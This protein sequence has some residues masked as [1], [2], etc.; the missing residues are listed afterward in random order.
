MSVKCDVCGKEVKPQVARQVVGEKGGRGQVNKDCIKKPGVK[1]LI[2]KAV[3]LLPHHIFNLWVYGMPTPR[4]YFF[5][6]LSENLGVFRYHFY[7][8]FFS[9]CDIRN[10]KYT[11]L[12]WTS[13]GATCIATTPWI[14][15]LALSASILICQSHIS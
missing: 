11:Y 9:S 12:I 7:S 10:K 4:Q 13:G 14:T 2:R 15:V 8:E 6:T 1:T 3:Q 5:H